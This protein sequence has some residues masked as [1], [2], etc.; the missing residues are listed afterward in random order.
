MQRLQFYLRGL[1]EDDVRQWKRLTPPRRKLL[2]W[3]AIAGAAYAI[4]GPPAA[5]IKGTSVSAYRVLVLVD[6]S[7]SM[8]DFNAAV[9]PQLDRLRAAG[10]PIEHQVNVPGWSWVSRTG[11][12]FLNALGQEIAGRSTVDAVYVVSD[13]SAG[14][15]TENDAV[16]ERRL[17]QILGGR[18]LRLYFSTVRDPVPAAYRQI[19]DS[20]GGGVV[21]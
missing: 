17:R 4:L 20:S 2:T 18:G 19:A 7:T 21:Q 1:D 3:L 12:G 15:N 13:F 10:I 6:D 9:R 8:P 5:S 16:G 14:D 11:Y